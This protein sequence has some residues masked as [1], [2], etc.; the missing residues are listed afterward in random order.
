[1]ALKILDLREHSK[2]LQLGTLKVF[3]LRSH[4]EKHPDKRFE[5]KSY[6]FSTRFAP[7]PGDFLQGVR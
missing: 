2:H 3:V 6:G 1:M 4:G 7:F 5:A